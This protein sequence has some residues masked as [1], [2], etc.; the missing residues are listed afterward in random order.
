[1]SALLT[2]QAAGAE[3]EPA[4]EG[5]A[6]W[7][8]RHD[9]TAVFLNRLAHGVLTLVIVSIVVFWATQALPG[10][11]AT[12]IAGTH[13]T[14]QHLHAIERQLNLT[15]P[16]LSQY[17][18]WISGIFEGRLGNSFANGQPVWSYVEPRLVDSAVL[19]FLAGF[20][21]SVV[22]IPLAIYAALHKDRLFDR[23][24]SIITLGI[25][26]IPDYIVGV[27]LITVFATVVSHVLPSESVIPLGQYAW[28]QPRL[29]VLPVATLA[30]VILPYVYRMT[31]GA[32]IE[33]LESDY[34]ELA[35][36][37]GLKPWRVSIVHALPNA[38]APVIQVSGL[39]YLY[40]AG[41]IVLVEF[42]FNYPGIGQGLW[43]AVSDRDVPTIQLIVLLLSGFYVLIN[44]L[45]DLA[46]LLVTP[47]RRY[48]RSGVK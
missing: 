21:G 13:A 26:G 4:A 2:S 25:A 36:L 9:L 7:R 24:M 15:R 33:T 37:K 44:I 5:R 8:Q 14:P 31:R 30:L 10:N 34:V 1:M 39:N 46:V 17:W 22:G 16:L 43:N 45:A 38:L 23:V 3:E 6:T 35:R 32:L 19:V 11:V 27:L 28:D 12:A 47:R 41:G 48:E 42:I 20:F 40:L 18:S 29:L